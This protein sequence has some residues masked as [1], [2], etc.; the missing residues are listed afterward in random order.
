MCVLGTDNGDDCELYFVATQ[1]DHRGQG[2]ARRLVRL[3]L[4]EAR[5]RGIA[6][7]RLQATGRASRSTRASATSRSAPLRCGSTGRS[8]Y[9]VPSLGIPA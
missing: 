9:S 8:A 1:P 6:V 7:S 2:L 3:A 4:T 5:E